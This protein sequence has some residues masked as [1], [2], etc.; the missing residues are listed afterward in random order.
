MNYYTISSF[1]QSVASLTKKSKDGYMTVVGDICKAL[2]DMPDNI[3]RDTNDRIKMFDEYRIVKLRIPNSGLKL[4]KANGFRLI[5]WVSMKRN[6]TVLLCVYPKRGPQGINSIVDA[7]YDRLLTEM[8][9]EMQ[10]HTLHQVDIT[11]SLAD[12][13]AT[14]SFSTV[15]KLD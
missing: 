14:A 12:L 7:E 6:N 4:A 9:Q 5:Y 3:L 11:N 15:N 8:I 10:A 1:R 13:S 2:Q